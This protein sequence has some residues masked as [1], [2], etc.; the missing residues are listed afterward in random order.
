VNKELQPIRPEPITSNIDVFPFN[1][2]TEP[3]EAIDALIEGYNILIVDFYSSGLTLLNALKQFIKI[4][5]N[6]QSFQGQR[7]FRSVFRE[8]SHHILLKIS[9]HKIIVKKAPEIG[10][11]KILYPELDEYLLPFTQVQGLNSSWQWYKKGIFIP[12]LKKKIHPWF[13]TYFPTRFEHLELFDSWLR[14]YKG[15]KKSAF[16]IGVGSGVLSFQLIKNGFEKV[17]G[18]DTNTNAIIGLNEISNQL[19][20]KLELLHGDLFVSSNEKTEMI[21]FNPPWLPA[22]QDLDELDKA[23]YYTPELFFR[24]FDKAKKHIQPNGRVVLLFS[25]IAQITKVDD[26]HP[27][28]NE[29]ANGGRFE[30]ELFLQKKVRLASKKTKRNQTWRAEEKVELWVLKLKSDKK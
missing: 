24:F 23:I 6:D 4:E 22:S 18:T 13:G 20:S 17:Y 19:Q 29:L 26:S 15:E 25:N 3:Q 12:V 14:R 16:D 30:K 28:E 5:Y 8:L 11:L 10:W 1:R 27:I 21:V 9:N 2:R 7:D